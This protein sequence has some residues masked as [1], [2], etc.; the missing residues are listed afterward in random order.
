[1]HLRLTMRRT[2]VV[3]V[4]IVV[5]FYISWELDNLYCLLSTL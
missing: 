2:R 1:M 5:V 3:V 4:V